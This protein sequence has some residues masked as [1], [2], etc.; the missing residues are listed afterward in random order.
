MPQRR[1]GDE[2]R[3]S[4]GSTTRC[5][6]RRSNTRFKN[7]QALNVMPVTLAVDA[8][9]GDHG[10]SV[11]VPAS[12]GFLEAVA[13]ARVILVGRQDLLDAALARYKGRHE[14]SV[15]HR[16]SIHAASEVVDMNEPPADAL[17]RKKDSS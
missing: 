16:V 4:L 5:I 14:S 7:G 9:G 11:T 3:R 1:L 2:L 13:D 6:L 15:G 17:R 8:M 12:I 10:P